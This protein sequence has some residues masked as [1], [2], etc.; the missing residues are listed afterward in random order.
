MLWRVAIPLLSWNYCA[1]PFGREILSGICILNRN[2]SSTL[3]LWSYCNP[4]K[5]RSLKRLLESVLEYIARALLVFGFASLL[6]QGRVLHTMASATSSFNSAPDVT[7][8][9]YSQYS[10]AKE[11][12]KLWNYRSHRNKIKEFNGISKTWSVRK[13]RILVR[14]STA[15]EQLHRSLSKIGSLACVS[16]Q[17]DPLTYERNSRY[18]LGDC[19]LRRWAAF[20]C[21]DV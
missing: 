14:L 20:R 11:M 3:L 10:V 19:R 8:S 15:Y 6:A 12:I 1:G 4:G 13:S 16:A 9:L 2:C 18:S 17:G 21:Q 7:L 5:I